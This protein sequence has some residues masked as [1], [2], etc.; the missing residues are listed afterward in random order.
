MHSALLLYNNCAPHLTQF[1]IEQQCTYLFSYANVQIQGCRKFSVPFLDG[2]VALLTVFNVPV[3][4]DH[5]FY[6][7]CYTQSNDIRR[8]WVLQKLQLDANL[9]CLIWRNTMLGLM[10]CFTFAL[11]S[12]TVLDQVWR[13]TFMAL[14]STCWTIE[15]SVVQ[16]WPSSPPFKGT[17][18]TL[19]TG[20]HSCKA[21]CQC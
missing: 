12:V 14:Q 9:K 4:F 20:D 3:H 16:C 15:W 21:K 1:D 5:L 2:N 8:D 11:W 18:N 10:L 7:A 17:V 19:T 13:Y 6:Y